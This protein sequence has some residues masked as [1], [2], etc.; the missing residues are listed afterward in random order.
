MLF[1]QLLHF[2]SISSISGLCKLVIFLP[3]NSSNSF[4]DPGT[5]LS[6][7]SHSQTG[8]GDP[9]YL[10]LEI[11]QSGAASMLLANLPILKCLGNQ[12]ID[13]LFLNNCDFIF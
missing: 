3:D 8:T 1:S 7:H 2:I 13:S 5:I 9:Q 6:P 4:I 10:F 12:L 11:F